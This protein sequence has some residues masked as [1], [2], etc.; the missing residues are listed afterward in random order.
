[1]LAAADIS[2]GHLLS[3]RGPYCSY[4]IGEAHVTFVKDSAH[5]EARDQMQDD[6]GDAVGGN[7][8]KNLRCQGALQNMVGQEKR[9]WN[10]AKD[11]IKSEANVN[12]WVNKI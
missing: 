6:P 1:M 2:H 4:H 8:H 7:P 10:C 5:G 12:Y 11:K 9:R 3:H